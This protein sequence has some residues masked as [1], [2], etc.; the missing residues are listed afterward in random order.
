MRFYFFL[1]WFA[2]A[3]G[4]ATQYRCNNKTTPCAYCIVQWAERISAFFYLP[5]SSQIRLN[6]V[7]QSYCNQII[8][9]WA[10]SVGNAANE[11]PRPGLHSITREQIP[12]RAHSSLAFIGGRLDIESTHWIW[13]GDI[14]QYWNY[15]IRLG[16]GATNRAAYICISR[17][18]S[19]NRSGFI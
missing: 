18:Q 11:T 3:N 17:K 16:F 4:A 14:V 15:G 6:L 7:R 10:T 1:W 8:A 5:D 12:A 13:M 19:M 9:S 2:S